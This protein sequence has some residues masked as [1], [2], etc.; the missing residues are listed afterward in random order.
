MI[1]LVVVAGLTLYLTII[2][3]LGKELSE[4]R[5]YIATLVVVNITALLFIGNYMIRS[6]LFPYSNYFIQTQLD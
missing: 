2:L 5:I 1:R 6:I 3:A 4:K